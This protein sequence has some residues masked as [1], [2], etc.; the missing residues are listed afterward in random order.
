MTTTIE[1]NG[2]PTEITLTPAQ[3]AQIKK[4]S[5]KVTDRIRSFSDVLK[6]KGITEDDFN[7]A[8]EGLTKD[9]IGYRKVKMLYEVLNEGWQPDWSNSNEAKYYPWMKFSAGSGFSSDG[10]VCDFAH[11]LVGS[12]LVLKSRELAEHAGQHFA[13]IINQFWL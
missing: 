8:C 12:R 6:E 2:K 11:S 13:D 10:Y 7:E 5:I 3:I 9:E 4:A 1:I